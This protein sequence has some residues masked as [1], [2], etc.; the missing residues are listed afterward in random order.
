M[1]LVAT[2]GVRENTE[3]FKGTNLIRIN[4]IIKEKVSFNLVYELLTGRA[5]STNTIVMGKI[6]I[7][8][9]IKTW[10]NP[11][12]RCK[13]TVQNN[14]LKSKLRPDRINFS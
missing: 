6:L 10:F 8:N 3:E 12:A 1:L 4:N 5:N 9:N 11:L 2:K 13:R 14:I 7:S